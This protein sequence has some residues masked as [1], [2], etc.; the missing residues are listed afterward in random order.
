VPSGG[1]VA[2][3]FQDDSA[4]A[5]RYQKIIEDHFVLALQGMGVN[6][7]TRNIFTTR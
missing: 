7:V 4:K 3:V 2:P 1:I 6:V 5:D